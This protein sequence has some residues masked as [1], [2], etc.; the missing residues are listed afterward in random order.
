MTRGISDGWQPAPALGAAG[1]DVAWLEHAT[2]TC[3]GQYR[4]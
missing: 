4:A 2:T 3:H 1:L